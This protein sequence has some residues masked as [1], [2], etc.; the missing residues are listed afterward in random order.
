[1]I[2]SRLV[3]P[4]HRADMHAKALGAGADEIVFDLEDAVAAGGKAAAR[5]QVARTLARPEWA[6]RPVAVRVNAPASAEHAGDLEL[7]AVA[8][9]DALSIVVPKVE[10]PADVE[11]A[12]GI[13]PVQALVESPRG[14]ALAAAVA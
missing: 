4:G 14:L 1:M 12:A 2:V 10:S 9:R 5:E 13:A 6:A 7:C 11:P 8:A 3:V